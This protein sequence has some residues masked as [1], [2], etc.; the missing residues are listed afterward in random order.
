MTSTQDT[1]SVQTPTS[2]GNSNSNNDDNSWMS[3]TDL[4]TYW[5]KLHSTPRTLMS[6]LQLEARVVGTRP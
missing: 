2:V 6:G 3:K 5:P 4:S 1:T